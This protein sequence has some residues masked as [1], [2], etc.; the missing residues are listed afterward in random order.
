MLTVDTAVLG[1]RERDVRRGFSLP[2]KIGLGTHRSTACVH[3]AGRGRSR[4]HEPIGFA[5]VRSAG[6]GR[7]RPRRGAR[8]ADVRQ[9]AVRPCPVV[10]RHRLDALDRGTAR[11]SLKGIQS[12]ADA[13]LAADRGVDAVIAVEPRRPSARRVAGDRSSS[14]R[15]SPTRSAIGSRSI[16]DGGVRRG[17]DIVK[18]VA[19][20]ATCVHGRPGV[21]LRPRCGG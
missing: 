15:P 21:P 5:N 18:A 12:V 9:R 1:R 4:A 19:L 13:V 10:G 2:P 3:P 8:L 17:S 14:S 20:G 6:D 7:R 16:C 11:S